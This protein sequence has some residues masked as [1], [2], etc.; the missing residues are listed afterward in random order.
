MVISLKRLK[1]ILISIF[2]VLIGGVLLYKIVCFKSNDLVIGGFIRENT[3]S[4]ADVKTVSVSNE[5]NGYSERFQRP[6][7]QP[8]YKLKYSAKDFIGEE[9]NPPAVKKVFQNPQEV[10]EAYFA[11][12][13]DAANMAGFYGGCGTI[14]WAKTPYPYAYELLSSETKKA[15]SLDKF[16]QSFSG[17]G[18]NTLLKLVPVYQPPDTPENIKYYMVET[19]IITGPKIE[20]NNDNL[21]KPGYFAYYYGLVTTEKTAKDGWKIKRIDYIPED[22]LCHPMHHWDYDARYLAGIVYHDWYGIID[23]NIKVENKYP[24]IYVYAEGKGTKY[25]FD[26]IRLTNGD[27]LLMHENI[28]ENGRW[29]EVNI[30]KPEHQIYKFSVLNPKLDPKYFSY[31]P[32]GFFKNIK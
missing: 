20:D 29:K 13:K 18:Q 1:L 32:G 7:S 12:I 23:E 15:L 30:L 8:A 17:V 27:D 9:T 14:G 10:I 21:P 26:F 6:S 3:Y 25:R 24:F 31:P 28:Y 16:I 11:L 2:T 5:E 22:F 19:E 4:Q